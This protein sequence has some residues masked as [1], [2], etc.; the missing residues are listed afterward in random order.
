MARLALSDTDKQARDWF[1]ETTK[2]LGCDVVVDAMGNTFAVRPGKRKDV[3][4]IYAGSHLDT[5]PAAGRYDGILGIVAG[6]ELLQLLRDHQ[7]ETA[8]PIGV[9]NW[10]KYVISLVLLGPRTDSV[11]VAV[12]IT[13]ATWLPLLL[14]LKSRVPVRRVHDFPCRWYHQASG[15]RTFLCKGHMTYKKSAAGPLP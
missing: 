4:P 3:A 5:Q 6:I 14:A 9:V 12:A 10:T 13:A 1:V 7:I 11:A 2:A 8:F 15:P